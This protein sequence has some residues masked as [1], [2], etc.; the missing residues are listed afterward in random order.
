M[1]SSLIFILGLMV[2]GSLSAQEQVGKISMNPSGS[3]SPYSSR[4]N[5]TEGG[6]QHSSL[7]EGSD[8]AT[9][10]FLHE[11]DNGFTLG[12]RGFLPMQAKPSQIFMGQAVGRF[13]LLNEIN[14]LYIEGT[15]AEGYLARSAGGQ[16]FQTFG[17]DVGLM[18]KITTDFA[19]GASLGADYSNQFVSRELSEV[20]ANGGSLYSKVSL[21]GNLY[22]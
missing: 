1:K 19:L 9:V 3:V 16:T 10:A 17:L 20:T 7:S 13:V 6:Y 22:F 12:I 11:F 5:L 15:A 14:Q 8:F 4:S 2:T 21:N 18:R